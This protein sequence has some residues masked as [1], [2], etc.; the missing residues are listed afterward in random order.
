[1]T[2]W[3]L[4]VAAGAAA[5]LAAGLW[6]GRRRERMRGRFL[7]FV[8]HEINTPI[9]ALNMTVLN[10]VQGTFGPVAPEHRPWLELIAGEAHRLAALVGDLR[11]LL[12]A[13]WH[14]DLRLELEPLPPAAVARKSLEAAR[15]A[16]ARAGVPLEAELP[17]G[18]PRARADADRLERVFTAILTHARK[19]R[20]RDAVRVSAGREAGEVCVTVRYAGTPVPAA[21]LRTA[22][23]LYHPV[24]EPESQVLA[25]V[26]LGLG[27]ARVLVEAHGGR[28]TLEIDGEGR[29][30]IAVS[31]PELSEDAR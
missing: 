1:M 14:R 23:D 26:G 19:F 24:R 27:M 31:L 8:A 5:G 15:A 10:F 30:R 29:A 22:L 28:M 12:H 20:T 13:E 4:G 9:T 6:L 17:D 21:E 18:L 25:G 16:F 3:L 7:S 11:D 2:G